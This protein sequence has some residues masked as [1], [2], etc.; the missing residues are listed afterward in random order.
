SVTSVGSPV[1]G[2]VSLASGNITFTPNANYNGP[3]A[4]TYTVSDGNGGTATATVNVTVSAVNDA[5]VAVN[6]S[7]TTA[8]DTP[9]GIA[10]HTPPT[11]DPDV[12]GDPFSVTRVG[13]HGRAPGRPS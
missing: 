10:A 5:P 6:D 3:A 2:T 13:N 4:F 1:N 12:D 8:E 7:A 11:N 9:L